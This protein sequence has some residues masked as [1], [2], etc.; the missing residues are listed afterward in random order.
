MQTMAFCGKW[1]PKYVIIINKKLLLIRS[2]VETCTNSYKN[3]SSYAGLIA[4]KPVLGVS[5]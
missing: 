4:R 1:F 3:G 5:D 2:K